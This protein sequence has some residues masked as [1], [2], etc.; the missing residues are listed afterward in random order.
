M[1]TVQLTST[2]GV[3]AGATA[4]FVNFTVISYGAIRALASSSRRDRQRRAPADDN[5]ND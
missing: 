1:S 3:P 2:A 4:A 5:R